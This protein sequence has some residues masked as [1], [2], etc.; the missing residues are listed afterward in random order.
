MISIFLWSLVGVLVLLPASGLTYRALRQRRTAK[1][2]AIQTP[3]QI[4][5]SRFVQIGGIEQ[6]LQIRGGD[7][8][9]PVL[10]VLHGG[11]GLSYAPFTPTFRAWEEYYTVVHWDQRGTGKTA[12]RS[13]KGGR[14]G[15]TIDRMAQ[16]GIEVTEWVLTHLDQ[17][18]LILFAHSWGTIL[19][20]TMLKRRPDLFSAY[21]GTG[22]IVAMASSEGLSYD[23]ALE[24]AHRRGNAR[25]C[26]ALEAIGRPPYQEV[27]TWLVKQRSLM[28]IVPRPAPGHHLPNIFTSALFSSGYSLKDAYALLAGFL[29]SP[30][31]LFQQMMAYDARQLGTTFETPVFFLQGDS[32]LQAPAK[33]VE[34]YF[35][36]I[37][38]PKK[39]L[40]LLENADHTAVLTM[41][42]VFL[43][44]LVARVR[45]V[46]ND[47]EANVQ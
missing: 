33:P 15:M 47:P 31:K 14:E 7:R 6:W 8:D 32:D 3:N 25:A 26:K 4:E 21:V 41:P 20:I 19:G 40:L 12:S 46:V 35:A 36:T 1:A 2:L 38:A 44:E 16:D 11:P 27:K 43:K 39:E 13:G 28:R 34:D 9:N 24:Q 17:R 37:Q 18:K 23:L 10:L 42:M 30:A 22:Q 45:P 29:S 5:E